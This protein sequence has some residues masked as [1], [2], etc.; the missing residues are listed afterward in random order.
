MRLASTAIV[1]S[2]ETLN[3]TR[4]T[5][6]IYWGVGEVFDLW[7][8]VPEAYSENLSSSGNPWLLAMLPWAASLGE[9]IELSL[10]VDA[11]LLENVQG[12]LA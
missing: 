9:D 12:I 1:S 11:L 6:R 8:D 5:G 7:V 10:P 4:L 3:S 2:P